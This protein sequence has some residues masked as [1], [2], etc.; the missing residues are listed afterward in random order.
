MMDL[1]ALPDTTLLDRM[2]AGDESA[3]TALYRRQGGSYR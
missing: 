2:A 1:S 3:V